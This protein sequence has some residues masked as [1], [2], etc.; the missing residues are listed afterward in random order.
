MS[1]QKFCSILSAPNPP[2]I[3]A[4]SVLNA[5]SVQVT[6]TAPTQPN[7]VITSY[8]ITYVT[9]DGSNYVVINSNRYRAMV[10]TV[11]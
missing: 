8:N 3:Q 5:Q 7:G 4:L 9:D 11:A 6:W 10:S 1:V 2:V